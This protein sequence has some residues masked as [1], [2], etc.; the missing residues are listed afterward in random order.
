VRK[1][2]IRLYQITNLGIYTK[3]QPISMCDPHAKSWLKRMN[4]IEH[5]IVH[6][7]ANGSELPCEDC[8]HR[9]KPKPR[10]SLT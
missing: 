9:G 10:K 1:N 6:K 3:G 5:M 2:P 8:V 7:I 4:T